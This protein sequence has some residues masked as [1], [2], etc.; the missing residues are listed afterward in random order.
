MV[1][2]SL[3]WLSDLCSPKQRAAILGAAHFHARIRIVEAAGFETVSSEP[4][5]TAAR[6]ALATW[7]VE[8]NLGEQCRRGNDALRT[9]ADGEV[10]T[11]DPAG[12]PR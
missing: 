5:G 2:E 3:E 6:N 10:G 8:G 4:Y 11:A 7:A 12:L 1:F 9:A